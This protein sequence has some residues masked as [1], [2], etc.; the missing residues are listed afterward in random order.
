MRNHG[1]VYNKQNKIMKLNNFLG[2]IIFQN[3]GHVK[4]IK[5]QFCCI[6]VPLLQNLGQKKI[7][8]WTRQPKLN[9][10]HQIF[11]DTMQKTKFFM[12]NL[13]LWSSNFKSPSLAI[14]S[15][16]II[17]IIIYFYDMVW[18]CQT[19]NMGINKLFFCKCL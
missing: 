17:I 13:F 16:F 11:F 10:I 7:R 4:V 3:E 1:L 2:W 8:I 19:I 5:W 18:G 12:C 14:T 9:I 6:V 15:W